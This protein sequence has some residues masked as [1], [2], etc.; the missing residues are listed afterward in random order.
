MK[1]PNT[2]QNKQNPYK[3]PYKF[4]HLQSA[5]IAFMGYFEKK[6]QDV[7]PNIPVVFNNIDDSYFF[8]KK[9]AQSELQEIYNKTPRIVFDVTD[10]QAQLEQR[11]NPHLT[12][13]YIFN[14][15]QYLCETRT[16]PTLI[17]LECNFVCSSYMKAMEYWEFMLTLIGFERV[18]TYNYHGNTFECSFQ[19]SGSPTIEKGQLNNS[20][21]ETKNSNIKTIIEFTII[22]FVLRTENIKEIGGDYGMV[23][24]TDVILDDN[25]NTIGSDNSLLDPTDPKHPLNTGDY[26]FNNSKPNSQSPN[27]DVGITDEEE[28][29]LLRNG[30]R[31]RKARNAF[32]LESHTPDKDKEQIYTHDIIPPK[33]D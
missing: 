4:H 20:T 19:S 2:K 8:Y 28:K 23:W 17:T 32:H 18:F 10:I 30:I 24:N 12:K 21:S 6:V 15:K 1:A 26:T 25:G 3:I 31:Q 9:Y 5:L 16:V 33:I 13:R 22:P 27:N 29:Q 11:S 14:D 7:F